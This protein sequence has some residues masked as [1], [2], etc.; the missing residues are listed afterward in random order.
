MGFG[1]VLIGI[2]LMV[3]SAYWILFGPRLI[4]V[5]NPVA[6][7]LVGKTIRAESALADF[8]IVVNGMLPPLIFLIGLFIVW[9]EWDEW[10]IERE[11]RKEEEKRKRVRR[12][13][14]RR[15]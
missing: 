13:R 12:K 4:N 5:L 6:H 11:L 2:G 14:K 7:Y 9:L 1:K 3:A 15:R 10:R 8:L